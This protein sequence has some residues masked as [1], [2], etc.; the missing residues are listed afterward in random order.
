CYRHMDSNHKLNS[1]RFVFQGC[2]DGYSR[3]ITYLRCSN[4]NR[5]STVLQ[6]FQEGVSRY[7]LPSRVRSDAGGENI[8]VAHFMDEHRGIDRGSF[9]VGRSVHNQ[10]IERLWSELN[11][12]LTAY[13]NDLFIFMEHIGILDSNNPQHIQVLHFV[14][15]PRINQPLNEFINQWNN[16][17][18]SS[19]HNMSPLQLWTLG[20]LQHPENTACEEVFQPH[21]ENYGVDLHGPTSENATMSE[22]ND[23]DPSFDSHLLEQLQHLINPLS[24]DGNH[25]IQHY[26]A[27]CNILENID[28]NQ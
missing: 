27:V 11:R 22:S 5:A 20:M 19:E 1:W 9:I 4:N 7:G 10:R 23:L 21:Y 12:V 6:L 18:L 28:I 16:H 14:F 15:L 17:S 2:V 13:F 8:D 3:C 24:D 26:L 25:G